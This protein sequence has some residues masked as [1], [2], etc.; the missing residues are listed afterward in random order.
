MNPG[1]I[2]YDGLWRCLCP[3]FPSRT[4]LRTLS[5]TPRTIAT[6]RL[7]SRLPPPRNSQ[8]SIS[9]HPVAFQTRSYASKAPLAPRSSKRPLAELS[10]PELYEKLRD[11]GLAGKPEPVKEIIKILVKDRG[12][13]PNLGI[14]APLLQSFASC[15]EGTA[16][17]VRKVLGEMREGGLELDVGACHCVLEALAIHPDYLLRDDIL[18]YMKERWF[19]LTESGHHM[20]AAGMLKDR[21]F[22][23]ALEKIDQMIGERV[24][25]RPWLLDMF[26]YTLMDYGE[27]EEAYRMLRLRQKISKE[28]LSY[29]L[30]MNMLDCA[31]RHHHTELVNLIWESQVQTSIIKP[32]TGTCINVLS[33]AGRAGNIRL[34]TDVFRI[35][36]ERG[37]VFNVHHYET[38]LEAYVTAEDLKSAVTLVVI[39]HEANVKIEEGT[40]SLLHRYLVQDETRA[41]TAFT[42]LQGLE[43]SGR[44][45][46]TAAVNACL[47]ASIYA[48]RLSEAIE[49]YK[50]LHTVSRSGPDVS[51]FNSLLKGCELTSRKELALFVATEMVE[52]GI[53][54]VAKTYDRLVRVCAK[55]GAL[56]DAFAYYEEM[57]G[58]EMVPTIEMYRELVGKGCEMGD[59]RTPALLEHMERLGLA[60]RTERNMVMNAFGRKEFGGKQSSEQGREQGILPN[61]IQAT[62]ADEGRMGMER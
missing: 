53:K 60:M 49:I 56:D 38:L 35:L 41:M 31:S 32:S 5:R 39:M 10:T 18:A 7:P 55:T 37:T 11:K 45:V 14:Y 27:V 22:E 62:E 44:V 2:V 57:M 43:Q 61:L 25:V 33:M 54:P 13:K 9:H 23:Q 51:T 46:P 8:L 52:L 29:T 42:V 4:A 15:S 12:E 17:K 19:S 59:P 58:Q 48:N 28:H 3:A 20:V 50:A 34:A 6:Q 30:W 40:L 21:L 47:R 1:P 24:R 16:G 36:A 26:I